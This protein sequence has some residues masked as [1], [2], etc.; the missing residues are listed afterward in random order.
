MA[1]VPSGC[2]PKAGSASSLLSPPLPSLQARPG[3]VLELQSFPAASPEDV[4]AV[5]HPAYVAALEQVGG[6]VEGSK[7]LPRCRSRACLDRSFAS[8]V[9]SWQYCHV[10][11]W[12]AQST[13]LAS[14]GTSSASTAPPNVWRPAGT[15]RTEPVS[16]RTSC[17]SPPSP[18]LLRV[19]LPLGRPPHSI[20][21]RLYVP[22]HVVFH[23]SA[24]STCQ[25]HVAY[26]TT[27]PLSS[28]IPPPSLLPSLFCLP[29]LQS[30]DRAAEDGLI[31]LEGSGPTYATCEVGEGRRE[32]K[33]M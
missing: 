10:T 26:D 29:P 8:A 3:Q 11:V 16:P 1:H 13:A 2:L 23:A 25:A 20:A 9:G 12:P 30:M 6:R 27:L 18:P 22:L 7:C 21:P 32:A 33:E 14:L 17:P 4:A 19:R 28:L 15:S 5:H 24:S 31:L